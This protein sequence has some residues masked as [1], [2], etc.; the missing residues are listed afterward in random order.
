MSIDQLAFTAEEIRLAA[1]RLGRR[2]S[3]RQADLLRDL[4]GGWP[5]AVRL[6]LM[7]G[8]EPLARLASGGQLRLSTLTDYLVEEVLGDLPIGLHDFLLR[9]SVADWLT[10]RLATELA[11]DELAPAMLEDAVAR[12]IPLERRGMAGGEPVYRWHPL[13]AEQCRTLLSRQDPVLADE[14]HVRA[15]RFLAGTE[16]ARAARH[17]LA[18][19]A[20]RLAY[21]IVL[22]HWLS[23]VLGGDSA[24]LDDVCL[25]LPAPWSDSPDILLIRATCRRAVDDVKAAGELRSRAQVLAVGRDAEFHERHRVTRMLAELLVVDDGDQL[26]VACRDVRRVLSETSLLGGAQRACAWFLVA[27]TEMRLRRTTTAVSALREAAVVARA[28][29]LDDIADRAVADLVFAL[30]FNGDFQPAEAL[31]VRSPGDDQAR[32]RRTEGRPEWFADAWMSFW[33]DDL[34]RAQLMFSRCIVAGGAVTSFATISRIWTTVAAARAG[35]PGAIRAA[36][37]GLAEL[38]DGTVGGLPLTV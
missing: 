5:V 31:L 9:V 17:A 1:G 34:E 6:A 27:F 14:L 22:E 30:A 24:V 23:L 33:R 20:P 18:G 21:G 3:D 4:T 28:E 13:V 26:L 10:A 12:G 25:Q 15:A 38:P 36:E 8:A 16:P 29:G 37:S 11:D 2:L 19:R 35:G 32:W 7:S